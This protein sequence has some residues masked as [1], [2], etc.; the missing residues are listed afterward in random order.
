MSIDFSYRARVIIALLCVLINLPCPCWARL[1]DN[2]ASV[3]DDQVRMRATL[4]SIDAQRYVM[5]EIA[6]PMGIVVR[7]FVSPQGAVFGVAWEGQFPPN[8]QELLGPY[9]QQ[10][11]Q[12]QAAVQ[13]SDTQQPPRR[14]APVAVETPGL[15]LHQTGHVRNFHGRA[16]IP[17]LVPEGV[18]ASE[19]H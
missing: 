8:L 6:A 19:I 1:G 4:R 9:Y 18:Q 10:A 11:Q 12:A 7:E 14:H 16:Y 3:L 5:H 17:E 2:A 13:H 15:V